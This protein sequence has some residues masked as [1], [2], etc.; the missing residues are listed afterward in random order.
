MSLLRRG[1][2]VLR[3]NLR[4]AGPSGPLCRLQY[5][6]GRGEDLRDALRSLDPALTRRGLVLIGYSL[7][8]NMLLKFLAEH[9]AGFDLRGAVS[10]SAPIDLSAASQRFLEPRDFAMP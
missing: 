5:H 6:A 9:A 4:G 1:Y 3:L 8:A 7:G 2:P 10:V